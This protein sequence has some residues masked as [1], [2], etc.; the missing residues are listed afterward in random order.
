MNK[1]VNFYQFQW[2]Y[3]GVQLV[4]ILHETQLIHTFRHATV[5]HTIK[6][7]TA[8]LSIEHSMTLALCKTC[9]VWHVNTIVR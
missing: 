3:C 9:N 5:E 7:S 6:Q 1:I 8:W 2:H 4:A